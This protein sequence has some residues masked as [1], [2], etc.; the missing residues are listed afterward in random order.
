MI[1]FRH[2]RHLVSRF[3]G[4]MVGKPLGPRAQDEVNAILDPAAAALFWDQD[5]IDQR[6]AYA[7]AQRVRDRL[8]GDQDA[9]A[10]ALLHD[11][12]KR[13]CDLGAVARSMATVADMMRL[14]MPADWRRYRDHGTLGA[15][16]LGEIGASPLAIAF[17]AGEPVAP[18]GI[19]GDVWDVLRAADDA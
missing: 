13:H 2:F 5:A 9:F 14:P 19:E 11:V 1:V 18:D 15:R 6:H 4:V 17:A 7:V 16:D 3:F 10:A 8:A 12:G